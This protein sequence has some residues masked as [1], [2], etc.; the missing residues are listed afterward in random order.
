MSHDPDEHLTFSAT[1]LGHLQHL[2]IRQRGSYV[3]IQT[4]IDALKGAVYQI[5]LM[6]YTESNVL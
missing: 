1:T 5:A 4:K 6:R 3:C 2:Q